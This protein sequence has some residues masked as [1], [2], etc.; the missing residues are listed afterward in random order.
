MFQEL[1]DAWREAVE[2]FRRELAGG[3]GTPARDRIRAMQQDLSAATSALERIERDLAAARREAA[4][5]RQEEAVCRRRE[6]MARNIGD[7]E[8]AAIAERFAQRHAERAAILE[9]KA[10][11]LE[12]E[13]D[14]LR[15]ELAEMESILEE[16]KRKA[17]EDGAAATGA[18][19]GGVRHD[20]SRGGGGIASDDAAEAEF[21]RL[22]R[23]ERERRAEA[24][25][26]E[27]KRRMR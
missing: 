14:L 27:L 10:A 3:Q 8:T 16:Q 12:A 18:A 17:G 22:E 21:R 7:A 23:E 20:A 4:S 6:A 1:K 15:R 11:V 13:R 26:E 5:A 19:S 2:N 9:Q 25:L 24:M